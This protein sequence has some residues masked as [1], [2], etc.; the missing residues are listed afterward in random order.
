MICANSPTSL[1]TSLKIGSNL[2]MLDKLLA[3]RE[4]QPMDCC[5]FS[6]KEMAISSLQGTNLSR[7]TKNSTIWKNF[8]WTS[9]GFRETFSQN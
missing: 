9:G 2:M 1:K 5:D 6:T 3:A 7:V 8:D 4:Q